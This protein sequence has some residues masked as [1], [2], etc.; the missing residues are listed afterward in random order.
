MHF[1]TRHPTP[2]DSIDRAATLAAAFV[3]IQTALC[4]MCE[5]CALPEWVEYGLAH[6]CMEVRCAR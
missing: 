2:S 3:T 4:C 6:V 1:L 5:L